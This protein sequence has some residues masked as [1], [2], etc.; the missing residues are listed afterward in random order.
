MVD[1]SFF[2][3]LKLHE[4]SV[5]AFLNGGTEGTHVLKYSSTVS[6]SDG[7]LGELVSTVQT[8]IKQK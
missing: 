6:A 3:S 4:F 2:L 5:L 8:A 1:A 7:Y